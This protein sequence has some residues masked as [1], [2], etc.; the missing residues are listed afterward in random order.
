M[1]KSEHGHDSVLSPVT[2]I[3]HSTHHYP[4]H[5]RQ[6]HGEA[7]ATGLTEEQYQHL[8]ERARACALGPTSMIWHGNP[9]AK[10]PFPGLSH[11]I[12][13]GVAEKKECMFK[14][15]EPCM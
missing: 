5:L 13:D 4:D 10:D 8:L 15:S 3:R 12:P 1:I 7:L 6:G 9:C 14:E 2:C 11:L